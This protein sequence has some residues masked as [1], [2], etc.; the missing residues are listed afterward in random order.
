M[1]TGVSAK[2]AEGRVRAFSRQ[3]AGPYSLEGR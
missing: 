1:G 2:Q 3:K